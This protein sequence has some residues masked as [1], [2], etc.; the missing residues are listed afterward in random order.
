MLS[1][2]QNVPIYH[3]ELKRRLISRGFKNGTFGTYINIFNIYKVSRTD[4]LF[5]LNVFV[6][7]T[8]KIMAYLKRKKKKSCHISFCAN[9]MI[10]VLDFCCL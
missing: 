8:E 10:N 4:P 1:S 5:I 7:W 2:V 9:I 6:W 3:L